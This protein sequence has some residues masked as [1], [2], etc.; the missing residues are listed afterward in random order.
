M[1]ACCVT[2][3]GVNVPQVGCLFDAVTAAIDLA[4]AKC[5]RL[6]LHA[7]GKHNVLNHLA[8]ESASLVEI[9]VVARADIRA[10]DMKAALRV[11]RDVGD[12]HDVFGAFDDSG[13]RFAQTLH[14]RRRLN[15]ALGLDV[16]NALGELA[17]DREEIG[18]ASDCGPLDCRIL[19]RD[20]A[21]RFVVFAETKVKEHVALQ[22]EEARAPRAAHIAALDQVAAARR[23]GPHCGRALAQVNLRRQ[24]K[25][26]ERIRPPLR[27]PLFRALG[28]CRERRRRGRELIGAA[29][30]RHG[31][32]RRWRARRRAR[33]RGARRNWRRARLGVGNGRRQRANGRR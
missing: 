22:N 28:L 11:E 9:V 17:V 14:P 5:G 10:A 19:E 20:C 8:G 26:A 31:A 33:R 4:N 7:F 30:G 32:P 3:L 13:R 16:E 21:K 18:P 25:A 23:V 1:F 6:L 15:S 29:R 24:T 12:V 27:Q 2:G